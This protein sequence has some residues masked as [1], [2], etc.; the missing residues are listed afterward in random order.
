MQKIKNTNITDNKLQT[1]N[2]KNFTLITYKYLQFGK[3][4]HKH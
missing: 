2:L 1:L 3:F 4:T